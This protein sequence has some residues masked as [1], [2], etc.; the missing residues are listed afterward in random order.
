[1]PTQNDTNDEA[2]YGGRG[3]GAAFADGRSVEPPKP[4]PDL[5]V[6]TDERA[7][8]AAWGH[9]VHSLEPNERA[10]D[11]VD[12]AGQGGFEIHAVQNQYGCGLALVDTSGAIAPEPLCNPAGFPLAYRSTAEAEADIGRLCEVAEDRQRELEN[13]CGM[14]L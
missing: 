9:D 1:M 3:R 11:L 2:A 7:A 4:Q 8:A 12:A 14:S 10:L 13:D 5:W 6:Q